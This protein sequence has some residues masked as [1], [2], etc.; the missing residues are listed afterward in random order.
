M[1]NLLTSLYSISMGTAETG[2]VP[3]KNGII[4][5]GLGIAFAI[6]FALYALRSVGLFVLAKKQG[7]KNYGI[8][9]VPVAWFYIACKLVGKTKFFDKPIE[10]LAWVF[11]LVFAGAEIL[12]FVYNFIIYFP[13]FE[14]VF[15]H[16]GELLI[17]TYAQGEGMMLYMSISDEVGIFV[18]KEIVPFGLSVT[19]I[20]K[21]LDGIYYA[22]SIFDIASIVVSIT[23][24]INLFRKFWPQNY[25]LAAILSIF[26]GLFPIFVFIIRNKPAVNYSEYMRARY[27]AYRNSYNNTYNTTYNNPQNN[28]YGNVNNQPNPNA[29]KESPFEEFEDKKETQEPFSEFDKKVDGKKPIDKDN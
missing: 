14:Y 12:T 21:I 20:N 25:M 22:S 3:M 11:C 7:I 1:A 13:L 4:W 15:I 10:K 2:I 26:L 27:E 8:A 16:N 18:N 23:I 29:Q 17:G 6:V 5:A 9:F 24:Y 19:T 28:P